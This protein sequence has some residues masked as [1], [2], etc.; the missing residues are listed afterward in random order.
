MSTAPKTLRAHCPT[1]KAER[2]A[3]VQAEVARPWDDNENRERGQVDYRVLECCGC[4]TLYFQKEEVSSNDH[5]TYRD[6]ELDEYVTPE[7]RT[8]TLYP[9]PARRHRP[10]W[11]DAIGLNDDTLGQLLLE[12]YTALDS[13]LRVLGAVGA[14]TTFDR[15][16]EVLEIDPA[17]P[18]EEKLNVL[19]EIGEIG[20]GERETLSTLTDAGNAAAHRGWRPSSRELDLIMSVLEGFLHRCFVLKGAM[21]RLKR[22]I[23]PKQKR[24]TPRKSGRPPGL[25][26]ADLEH[27]K[28]LLSNPSMTVEEVA[29]H[30]NVAPSTLYRHFPGGRRAL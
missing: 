12:T 4:E 16:T 15:A 5:D 1:C 2:K 25:A 11:S 21:E 30:L 19:F 29:T 24:K 8:V 28:E 9:P 17:I 14:R 27:A 3:L 22:K 26:P 7:H 6:D 13:D 20:Q 10:E 23:P 18:F